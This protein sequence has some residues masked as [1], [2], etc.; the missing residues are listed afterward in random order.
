MIVGCGFSAFRNDNIVSSFIHCDD[1]YSTLLRYL[2]RGTPDLALPEKDSLNIAIKCIRKTVGNKHK[3]RGNPYKLKGQQK[4]LPDRGSRVGNK[5]LILNRG[6]ESGGSAIHGWATQLPQIFRGQVMPR[7]G[8]SWRKLWPVGPN[9]VNLTTVIRCSWHSS[10][11]LVERML[12]KTFVL[13][14]FRCNIIL[15]K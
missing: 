8:H 14:Q 7:S 15:R 12:I 10:N 9:F 4:R 13:F 3:A 5:K 11:F 6:A 2:C 1:L